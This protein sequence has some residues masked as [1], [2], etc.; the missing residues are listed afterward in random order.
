MHRFKCC[1]LLK[2]LTNSS[3]CWAF[4]MIYPD[5]GKIYYFQTAIAIDLGMASNLLRS[6]S[7]TQGS[8]FFKN[9][10][11]I[12][13]SNAS[14]KLDF[15]LGY[16]IDAIFTVTPETV[17]LKSANAFQPLRKYDG[18]YLWDFG[19]GD[20][21][22]QFSPNHVYKDTGTY[23]VTLTVVDTNSCNARATYSKKIRVSIAPNGA[24]NISG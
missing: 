18:S 1:K 19:D 4:F 16:S 7:R 11:S 5:P 23:T 2:S 15:R 17:C 24:C 12:R 14:F 21:S 22:H 20:T 8:K 10:V 6:F 13:C 3:G 9:N